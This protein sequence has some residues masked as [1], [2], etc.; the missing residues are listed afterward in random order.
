[1]HGDVR[2]NVRWGGDPLDLLLSETR[3]EA[4]RSRR[5]G[6]IA[7][8]GPFHGAKDDSLL[9]TV[10]LKKQQLTICNARTQDSLVVTFP[11]S[12]PV[13]CARLCASLRTAGDTLV[14]E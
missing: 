9:V 12:S 1:M 2:G 3:H 8:H 4:A 14:I 5:K 13:R 6:A 10:D 11:P 7:F